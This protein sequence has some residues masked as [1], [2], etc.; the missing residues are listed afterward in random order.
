MRK[1]SPLLLLFFV[2]FW[3]TESDKLTEHFL[4][5]SNGDAVFHG[6]VW[7]APVKKNRASQLPI[8]PLWCQNPQKSYLRQSQVPGFLS[9]I[10]T[11]SWPDAG[12]LLI[13]E[14]RHHPHRR[15]SVCICP[16][17]L[18][19]CAQCC[20]LAG[21]VAR[22]T[23][24]SDGRVAEALAFLMWPHQ[25]MRRRAC[26]TFALCC[27][28]CEYIHSSC[29]SV[30]H[31]RTLGRTMPA[32]TCHPSPFT[33]VLRK[34]RRIPP[35]GGVW[36]KNNIYLMHRKKKNLS[37]PPQK[38]IC[39]IKSTFL[40][41]VQDFGRF[42]FFEWEVLIGVC[43]CVWGW[44]DFW[45]LHFFCFVWQDFWWG[46]FFSVFLWVRFVGDKNFGGGCR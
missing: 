9:H 41:C 21:F 28:T 30:L 40:G 45:Y 2:I 16:L 8:H 11:I 32:L 18:I 31:E 43:V 7:E 13:V 38:N 1:Y 14:R 22:A 33:E 19:F 36:A 20:R 39:V 3:D 23:T 24:V 29:S 6:K 27:F 12:V 26:P 35:S 42:F 4:N 34:R 15:S 5:D 46:S 17:V 37:P 25:K 10:G 44:M